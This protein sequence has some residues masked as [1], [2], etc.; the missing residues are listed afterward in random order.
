MS[1]QC[2]IRVFQY[3]LHFFCQEVPF[4]AGM[5]LHQRPVLPNRTNLYFVFM[6]SLRVPKVLNEIASFRTF[7]AASVQLHIRNY[8][9]LPIKIL[10]GLRCQKECLLEEASPKKDFPAICH[11]KPTRSKWIENSETLNAVYM[12]DCRGIAFYFKLHDSM[13]VIVG[14]QWLCR[15][16]L[17]LSGRSGSSGANV[18]S[19]RHCSLSVAY[20]WKA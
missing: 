11:R 18:S 19:P 20:D 1:L 5:E 14:F 3:S 16:L 12:W 8:L 6:A 7:S 15:L 13:H 9:P 10:N 2:K 4:M 17:W